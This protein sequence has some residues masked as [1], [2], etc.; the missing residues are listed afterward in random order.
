[1]NVDQIIEKGGIDP[2]KRKRSGG[3]KFFWAHET[4]NQE[5]FIT[6]NDMGFKR[7]GEIKFYESYYTTYFSLGHS[8]SR[9]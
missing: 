1:M 5:N 4:L 3:V 9:T 8:Y 7:M 6:I 2:R